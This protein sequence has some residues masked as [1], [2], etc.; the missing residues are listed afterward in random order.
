MTIR[1]VFATDTRR[2]ELPTGGYG[3]IQKGT[4][5]P[6]D[7]P[8]V[9]AHPDVFSDDPRW[10]MLYSREPEGYDAPVEQTTAAPGE[11][12]NVVRPAARPKVDEAFEEA[13][14]LRSELLRLGREVDGRWSLRRLREEMEKVTQ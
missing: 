9:K 14:E 5:W 4:H 2:V 3:V 11:K 6:A 12:R 10:G 8:I 13:E 1:V 7:D